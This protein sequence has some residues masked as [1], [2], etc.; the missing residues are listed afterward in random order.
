M[1]HKCATATLK[2][3][4]TCYVKEHQSLFLVGYCSFAFRDERI[5]KKMFPITPLGKTGAP[6]NLAG[7]KVIKHA[8]TTID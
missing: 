1:S 7:G 2:S 8:C 5:P 4:R 6:K 3:R